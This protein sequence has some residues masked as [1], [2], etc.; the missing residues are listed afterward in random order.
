[1]NI[2]HASFYLLIT[3]VALFGCQKSKSTTPSPPAPLSKDTIA[4]VHWIGKSRLAIDA[5]SYFLM[6]LWELPSGENLEKQALDKLAFAPVLSHPPSA[7]FDPRVSASLL[8]PVLEAALQKECYFEIRQFSTNQYPET[9]FAIRL[10]DMQ[11]GYFETNLAVAVQS[12]TSFPAVSAPNGRRGWVVRKN[13]APNLIEVRR[14]GEWT[15][16]GLSQGGNSL[17]EQTAPGASQIQDPF[18][19]HPETNYWLEVDFDPARLSHLLTLSWPSSTNSP[20]ISMTVTGDGGNVLT[21]ADLIFPTP[22]NQSGIP[23]SPP[24]SGGEGRGEVVHREQGTTSTDNGQLTSDTN[25]PLVTRRS[26]LITSS[27]LIPA[28]LIREPVTSFTAIRSLATPLSTSKLWADISA[29]LENSNPPPNQLYFWS[30]SGSPFQTYF[31]APLPDGSNRVQQISDRLMTKGNSWLGAHNYVGFERLPDSNGLTWGTAPYSK[32]FITSRG[33]SDG[34]FVFGGLLPNPNSVTN[35][36]VRNSLLENLA[37]K[38]NLVYFDWEATSSRVES[39]LYISQMART[40]LG[41]AEL[42]QDSAGLTW[43][44]T[45]RSRLAESTTTITQTAPNRLTF[46]RKSTLGLTAPELH[47]LIDWLESP[48]FPFGLYTLSP[49]APAAQH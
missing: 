47:L 39:W 24:R 18:I 22:I 36:P 45:I 42:P 2:R 27:W 48:R 20:L 4:R 19:F 49:P 8:R 23:P 13:D 40:I 11:D 43:L 12:I 31:A 41:H 29:F 38:T 32:P 15:F 16:V 26:P 9:I 30:E 5:G 7:T 10:N 6:R 35:P 34:G 17:L 3:A 46:D 37:G 21:H 28:N 14:V 1:M 25:S 33:S 44:G